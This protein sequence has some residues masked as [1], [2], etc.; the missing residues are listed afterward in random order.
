[1]TGVEE[2]HMCLAVITFWPGVP[3]HYAGDEQDT[4]V[5]FLPIPMP[6]PVCRTSFK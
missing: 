4:A 2:T 5:P 1:M 6:K 3:L